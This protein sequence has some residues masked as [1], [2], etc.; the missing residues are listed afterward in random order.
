MFL[1]RQYP[2]AYGRV[3]LAGARPLFKSPLCFAS[4]ACHCNAVPCSARAC[5]C[6][7]HHLDMLMMGKQLEA[8]TV[9]SAEACCRK[10]H[11]PAG[12]GILVKE[13]SRSCTSSALDWHAA[14]CRSA[15]EQL[16]GNCSAEVLMKQELVRFHSARDISDKQAHAVRIVACC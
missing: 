8:G 3:L 6:S 2:A 9:C 16:S 13:L 7:G 1:R 11:F 15:R 10:C 14:W 12:G 4:V 5:L